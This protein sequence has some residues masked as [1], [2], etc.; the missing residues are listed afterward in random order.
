[1]DQLVSVL[2]AIDKV[3]ILKEGPGQQ[4]RLRMVKPSLLGP[5]VPH[6]LLGVSVTSLATSLTD[7]QRGHTKDSFKRDT[8]TN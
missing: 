8:N 4:I 6:P 3:H 1:M 5:T 2:L 7:V